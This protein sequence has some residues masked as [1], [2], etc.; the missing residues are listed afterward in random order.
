MKN[1]VDI[2]TRVEMFVDEWLIEEKKGARLKPNPPVK[3][4]VVLVLD[5]PWEDGAGCFF[6]V[7]P[8]HDRIRLYYRGA[9]LRDTDDETQVACYAESEDGI[10]FERPSLGL[11]EHEGSKDNNIFLVGTDAH[12][13]A[14]FLDA[15]PDAPPQ[16]RFKAV[17][18]V[19]PKAQSIF[20]NKGSLNG[21]YSSDGIHWLKY[22]EPILRDGAFDSLNVAFWD[23]NVNEY[24]CYSRY[25][26]DKTRAVQVASSPDFVHWGEHRPNRYADGVPLEQFY[27]NATVQCPG[28]E[29]I[30]LAFPMRLV[31]ERKKNRKSMYPGV[32][33]AVMMSSRDGLHWDRPFLEAWVRPGLDMNNWIDRNQ[34]VARGIVET[35]PDEFSLYVSE[36]YRC[37]DSRLRRLTVRKHGFASM[38]A[39]YEGGEFVTCPVIFGGDRLFLNYSTSAVGSI[40]VE[41]QDAEGVPIDG[42]TLRDMDDMYGDSIAEPVKWKS[43]HS[44][45]ELKGE[46]VRFRFVL[47][48][49]D[50]FAIRTED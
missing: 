23:T 7:I 9:C 35:G 13:F 22:D 48:D 8:E 44:L 4:E 27:T 49:A 40:R 42:F 41:V 6:T 1:A 34:M 12:N 26:E 38:H 19:G 45:D 36:H 10:H 21:Y 37:K 31:P 39:G 17:A 25:F 18:G 29:H 46:P 50:L 14:P 32:S 11:H 30:Y 28:A 24:R 33:D 20:L 15:S 47:K 43:G 2:G 5:R 3:R 16:L